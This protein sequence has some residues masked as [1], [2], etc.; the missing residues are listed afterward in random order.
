MGRLLSEQELRTIGLCIIAQSK[1]G[2][3]SGEGV[4]QMQYDTAKA[5]D[6][7]TIAVRDKEWVMGIEKHEII[8]DVK[9]RGNIVITPAEWQQL[10]KSMGV[11]Q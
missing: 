5:Q 1:D 7:K 10:L 2:Y 9:F 4:T 6:I 8:G 11:S 3:V